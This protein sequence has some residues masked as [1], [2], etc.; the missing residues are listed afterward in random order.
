MSEYLTRQLDIIPLSALD[1]KINVIGV[2]AIGSFTVLSL[3]K[4]G[5]SDITVFD[6]DTISPENM[7]CQFFRTKDIGKQKVYALYDL[8]KDFTEVEITCVPRRWAGEKLQGIVITSVDN[9]DVRRQVWEA[10]QG[11]YAEWVVDPRMSAEYALLYVMSPSDAKD[12][13]TY[14]KVLYSD[15]DSVQERCTAKSTMYTVGMI[16]GLTAKAVKSLVTDGN[17]PRIAEWDIK[18][19]GL[20]IY[21]KGERDEHKEQ[22]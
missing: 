15:K 16:A 4:M 8:V 9:M 11:S 19:N 17:Y 14:E 7:N 1:K 2:G 20:D 18:N 6:D 12:R 13:V 21:P 5:F 10:H 3:A 22:G